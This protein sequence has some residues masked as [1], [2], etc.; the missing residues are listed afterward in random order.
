MC[1]QLAAVVEPCGG[2]LFEQREEAVGSCGAN[3]DNITISPRVAAEDASQAESAPSRRVHSTDPAV[4][5]QLA[6]DDATG[7][8]ACPSITVGERFKSTVS[9]APD[10]PALCYKE[11]EV[12]REVTYGQYYALCVAS[13]KSLLKVRTCAAAETA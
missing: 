6:I 4:G 2:K 13:A 5:I 7:I 3:D 12:W 1:E 8:A 11:A 9:R 10:R